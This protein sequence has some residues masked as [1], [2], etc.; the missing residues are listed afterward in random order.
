VRAWV[1]ATPTLPRP[2][3]AVDGAAELSPCAASD[4]DG[5]GFGTHS[6]CAA[7]DCDDR[8]GAVY[9]GA[10]EACNGLDDN[11]EGAVDKGLG[12]GACG[13]GACRRTVPF[14]VMGRPARCAPG[15]PG[16]E[17][18]N[19]LDDD[20]DGAVD[21]DAPGGSCGVG[22]CA[23]TARCVGGRVEP[24]VPGAPAA[25]T[26][27]GMDDD[28]DGA[29]DEGL[30]AAVST[31]GYSALVT[32]HPGCNGTTQRMGP[33]CNAAVHR[34][35]ARRACATTGFG[36]AENSGDVAVVACVASDGLRSVSFDDLSRQH[37]DCSASTQRT[38][39]HC[40]SAIHRWCRAQGFASGF[41][42]VEQGSAEALVACLRG[43]IA[44]PVET[45]F[46]ELAAAHPGCTGGTR[47]WGPDCN[48]AIH[49][50]C[51]RRGAASGYGPVEYSSNAAT[52]VCVSP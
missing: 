3:A 11:C 12:E 47:V 49:R 25:E 24:C 36:P 35:C 18:C 30:R 26:C 7:R 51:Q 27:N 9:P 19:G 14:C 50:L 45:S 33:D 39:V 16:R 40:N 43:A 42:P 22:L 20:C 5:D 4:G 23:R 21:D 29:I 34:F 48:A 2:D 15:A 6:T 38:G 37:P 32:Q 1:A 46:T 8:N 41:G 10:P 13:V 17:L 31:T 28:C 52:V 44:T